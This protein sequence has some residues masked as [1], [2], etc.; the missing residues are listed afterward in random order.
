MGAKE[1][2]REKSTWNLNEPLNNNLTV[3]GATKIPFGGPPMGTLRIREKI[4]SIEMGCFVTLY[5][6]NSFDS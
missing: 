6:A 4:I 3:V 1:T 2:I 5:I